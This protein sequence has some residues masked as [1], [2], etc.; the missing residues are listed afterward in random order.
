MQKPE[1]RRGWTRQEGYAALRSALLYAAAVMLLANDG[2]APA[3]RGCFLFNAR[4]GG[5]VCP[6]RRQGVVT[7]LAYVGAMPA[8]RVLIV[9]RYAR[10]GDPDALYQPFFTIA[11]LCM[12]DIRRSFC[13]FDGRPPRFSQAF[14]TKVWQAQ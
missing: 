2:G 12:P 13:W 8:F 7:S 3:R 14:L 11:V 9:G 1:T 6:G 5:T 4:G 10:N